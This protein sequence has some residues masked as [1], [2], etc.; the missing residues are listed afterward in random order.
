MLQ[1]K[2]LCHTE[3]QGFGYQWLSKNSRHTH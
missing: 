1:V 2:T 3:K